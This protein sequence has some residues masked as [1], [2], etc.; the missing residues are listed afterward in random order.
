[1]TTQGPTSAEIALCVKLGECATEFAELLRS[2]G[3]RA[4]SPDVAEF[5]AHIHA[6]QH[7]VMARSAVRARPDVFR[8]LRERYS[9]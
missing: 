7:A 8:P 9:A 4:G 1:M 5:V 2:D 3:Q 6:L